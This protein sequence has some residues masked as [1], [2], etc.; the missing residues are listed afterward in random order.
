[1][2]T[3][4]ISTNIL[5]THFYCQNNSLTTLNTNN[6]LNL[7]HLNCD[8]N[9]LI[10][11]DVSLNTNLQYL[12]C[13][14]NTISIL[15]VSTLTVL[16]QFYCYGNVLTSLN[17]QNGNNT[18]LG[19][20]DATGNP[21][22]FCIQVDN[23]S[24]MNSTWMA[25]KDANATFSV[26]CPLCSVNIPDANFKSALVGN[27][28]INTNGNGEIEC[29]EASAF[30]GTINVPNSGIADLTGIEA[31]TSVVG[32]ICNGN[33]L[34]TLNVSSNTALTTLDCRQNAL[35]TLDVSANTS[36]QTLICLLNN[37]TSLNITGCT[38]LS[39]LNC[40]GNQLT[41]LDLSTNTQLVNINASLNQ[42]SSLDVSGLT[43]L[44]FFEC[45]LNSITSLDVSANTG[46]THFNCAANA[47][48]SLNMQNGNNASL[49]YF[50]AVQNFSL[51]CIQVDNPTYMNTNYS[52]AKDAGATYSTICPIPNPAS[53]L[54]F[55]GAD[56]KVVVTN[57][58]DL[59]N[60]SFSVEMWL[61]QSGN[62]DYDIAFSQGGIGLPNQTLHIGFNPGGTTF[63]FNF[64]YNDLNASVTAD[65]N[66]H[67]WTCTF[68][69]VTKARKIYR[70]GVL[71][72]SDI[73]PD[74]FIGS[75]NTNLVIGDN[76]WGTN[77]FNGNID[78]LRVWTRTLSAQEVLNNMSCEISSQVGL[79]AAYHFNQGND[80]VNNSSENILTDATANGYNGT[81]QNFALNGTS[82]NWVAPGGVVTGTA[83]PPCVV[84]IPDA[85]FK[86]ALLSN[87]AINTNSDL[88]IQCSEAATYTGTIDVSN[89]GISNL[90]G[91]EAFVS[92]TQ[93]NCSGNALTT[94]NV[95]SNTL[96]THLDATSNQLSGLDVSNNLGLVLLRCGANQLTSLNVS[97]NTALTDLYCHGNQL[98]IL[99]ISTN[100]LLT[101]LFCESNQIATL[102]VS[103]NTSLQYVDCYNNNITSLD[104]SASTALYFL[105]CN[106]NQLTSLNVQNGNNTNFT[107][108]LALNN[109]VLT[110]IQVDNV[111]YSNTNW[112]AGKDAG[113]IF[114]LNCAVNP[115]V[116]IVEE[117][118]LNGAYT[119]IN[120][121][122]TAATDGDTILIYPRS[123]G[124]PFVED[125][126]APSKI[127][128]HFHSATP[129][130]KYA[131]Q[132]NVTLVNGYEILEA[133]ITGT[134]SDS[135]S[136]AIGERIAN[137]KITGQ[138]L[139]TVINQNLRVENDSIFN[140]S[141]QTMMTLHRGAWIGNYIQQTVAGYYEITN[142]Y[143]SNT[144]TDD[145]IH[146][147]GNHFDVQGGGR[148]IAFWGNTQYLHIANNFLRTHGNTNAILYFR[149]LKQGGPG[150][151]S[152]I[153]NTINDDAGGAG[154]F[155]QIGPAFFIEVRNNLC[156]NSKYGLWNPGDV[157]FDPF[158]YNYTTQGASGFTNFVADTTNKHTST[159]SIALNGSLLD[160]SDAING[161]D[162]NP[163][164]NDLNG[165]RND[166]GAFGGANSLNNYFPAGLVDQTYYADNDGDGHGDFNFTTLSYAQPPS[167]VLSFDDC[168][169]A[170]ITAYPGAAEL[171]SMVLM[172]IVMSKLMK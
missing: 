129:G 143:S 67:H 13:A 90:T 46:L 44:T 70:D 157:T 33:S 9:D 111:S 34:S 151:N 41:N 5:L 95:S 102:D 150:K 50:N 66:W 169:D 72:A 171:V 82:S 4:D 18:N 126:Y 121:A 165:T 26:T 170:A 49:T 38:S 120:A 85:N 54:N 164:Y 68:D 8:N 108:F 133:D 28:L 24:Y 37:L 104:F 78:E 97:A 122:L 149:S 128:L 154:M 142:V 48:T 134:V 96:L 1:M 161:G 40:G 75:G 30:N 56:D 59:S 29:T 163:L 79:A 131:V 103:T 45:H 25:G 99:D 146:I 140:F 113:A 62:T 114:S 158:Q 19:N 125:I 60:K 3:M 84:N 65:F 27:A 136:S 98:T 88:E 74:A 69:N 16:T 31:F 166:A 112:G 152:C 61:K 21:L 110:C 20:V 155:F 86:N 117:N 141:G 107:G 167:Y 109:P 58:V 51:T 101:A 89:A 93:L 52:A 81:L 43:G 153:N 106:S 132:G 55:D 138:I 73:S 130:T 144:A 64:A 42:L 87:V 7:I 76:A 92:L 17:V 160:N 15:D 119:T 57:S 91:I 135:G 83:C 32:L 162:P 14:Q 156:I 147:I 123:G 116:L 63:L 172:M 23:A 35:T 139:G 124:L 80:G 127:N 100:T 22:L 2:T 12:S 137:S 145:S 47:L 6:N 53:A 36:L 115:T 105:N 148:T 39:I 10:A 159:S 11:L 118:G 77:E 71:V 94:L 168:N